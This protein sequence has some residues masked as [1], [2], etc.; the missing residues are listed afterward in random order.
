MENKRLFYNGEQEIFKKKTNDEGEDDDL[1]TEYSHR[2][3]VIPFHK[4]VERG[5]EVKVSQLI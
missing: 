4:E 2:C 3:F 1:W 5:H